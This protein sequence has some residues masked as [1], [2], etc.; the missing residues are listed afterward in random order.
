MAHCTAHL[1][2]CHRSARLS[3]E[4]GKM[5]DGGLLGDANGVGSGSVRQKDSGKWQRPRF[6]RKALMRCCLLRWI[7]TSTGPKEQEARNGSI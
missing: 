7:F 4:D 1:C 2:M 6:T 5:V 3:R